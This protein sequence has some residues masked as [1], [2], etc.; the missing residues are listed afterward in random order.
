MF[1]CHKKISFEDKHLVCKIKHS[2][3]T[4]AIKEHR[5]P[6]LLGDCIDVLLEDD[7]KIIVELDD[8]VDMEIDAK[9]KQRNKCCD[10]Q[11][12]RIL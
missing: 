12:I 6:I 4:K 8:L 3:I 2:E 5:H 10:C 9:K 1:H 7:C 11:N